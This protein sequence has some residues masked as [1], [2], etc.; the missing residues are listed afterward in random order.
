MAFIQMWLLKHFSPQK[1]LMFHAELNVC[2]RQSS[3]LCS[4][5]TQDGKMRE[6][7][8]FEEAVSLQPKLADKGYFTSW[9]WINGKNS[10]S[11]WTRIINW[12]LQS[13]CFS[14]RCE[15]DLIH[16][17]RCPADGD[18]AADRLF[19]AGLDT[20]PGS[21]WW[22]CQQVLPSALGLGVCTV[23]ARMSVRMGDE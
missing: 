20:G 10:R 4:L 6:S 8:F 7:I 16:L 18:E 22:A 12:N 13:G 23:S 11:V 14:H 2:T 17:C 3:M 21:E 15:P 9:V 19:W 1:Q 5:G